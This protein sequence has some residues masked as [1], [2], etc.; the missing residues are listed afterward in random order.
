MTAH[1]DIFL[2]PGHPHPS[3]ETVLADLAEVSGGELRL[4]GREPVDYGADLGGTALDVALR[5]D[6][7]ED[8]GIPFHRYQVVVTVR[9]PAGDKDREQ[10]VAERLFHRLAA[11]QRYWLVLVY[12]LQTVIGSAAP[13]GRDPYPPA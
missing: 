8:K 5:H 13:P 3:E 4:I 6:Y 1:H 2:H 7:E 11:L 12:D 10:A 9:D